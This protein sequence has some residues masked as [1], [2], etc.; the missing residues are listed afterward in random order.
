MERMNGGKKLSEPKLGSALLCNVY[1]QII[2]TDLSSM[3][4][5]KFS[6]NL[7]NSTRISS[8]LSLESAAKIFLVS[9]K[10]NQTSIIAAFQKRI[11]SF[12]FSWNASPA[13]CISV[14]KNSHYTRLIYYHHPSLCSH[15][16]IIS[17]QNS[18]CLYIFTDL[19]CKLQFAWPQSMQWTSIL[20]CYFE[21]FKCFKM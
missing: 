16:T 1:T 18:V 5:I 11:S 8:A 3:L 9:M 13:I 15:K 14:R 7:F 4:Y 20:N 6:L 10:I 21:S 17:L 19:P 12:F 2:F